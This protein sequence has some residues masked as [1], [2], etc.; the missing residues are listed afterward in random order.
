MTSIKK[1]VPFFNYPYLFKS[2]EEDFIKIFKDVGNRDR[3]IL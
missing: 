3:N 2:R 1:T